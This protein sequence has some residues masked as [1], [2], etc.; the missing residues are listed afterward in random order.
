MLHLVLPIDEDVA[1]AG[2]VE[3]LPPQLDE[4][5]AVPGVTTVDVDVE[6]PL[7][8]GDGAGDDHTVAHRH[9]RRRGVDADRPQRRAEVAERWRSARR[10]EEQMHG[11]GRRP[12]D[13]EGAERLRRCPR[14]PST[15]ADTHSRPIS[16]RAQV[17][18]GTDEVRA[19]HRD[20]GGGGGQHQRREGVGAIGRA[21][22][23][24]HAR[25]GVVDQPSDQRH[26][27]DREGQ[28]GGPVTEQ[29]PPAADE[30][31]EAQGQHADLRDVV[32]DVPHEV[33]RVGQ[34]CHQ[35]D[36]RASEA[37]GPSATAAALTNRTTSETPSRTPS[38]GRRNRCGRSGTA[39]ALTVTRPG[40]RAD[41]LRRD[42]GRP[43]DP[44][45]TP[46]TSTPVCS[47]TSGVMVRTYPAP[48][49]V[50][51]IA[52]VSRPGRTS[53]G[54]V[55]RQEISQMGVRTLSAG[56]GGDHQQLR[57]GEFERH[58]EA[59]A[60]G[61]RQL[62]R[63]ALG[64]DGQ[65]GGLEAAGDGGEQGGPFGTHRQT[66]GHVLDERTGHDGAV[67]ASHRGAHVEVAVGRVRT[68]RG[69]RS[70]RKPV[71]R[72]YLSWRRLYPDRWLPIT[73]PAAE[74][75]RH[76]SVVRRWCAWDDRAN[77]SS[78]ENGPAS[79]SSTRPRA[80]A[81][82]S[83]PASSPPATWAG[84]GRCRARST[85]R[86]LDQLAQRGYLR[87]VGEEPGIAGGNRTILAATRTGRAQLRRWL[88]TPVDHLRDL[89][90]ELLLKLIIADICDIDVT[91]MLGRQHQHI[92]RA[93]RR[94][95]G[96]PDEQP[97]DVV[98]LWRSESSK[99]ALRFLERLPGTDED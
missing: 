7:V 29:S 75:S 1:A 6:Q 17:R 21:E 12:A 3:R 88:A 32:G 84:C 10:T 41:D 23:V 42:R 91:S 30:C 55:A 98:A 56:L 62:I 18:S 85:Y 53:C 97:G 57:P 48:P 24:D 90:S 74:G 40:P 81:S 51:G 86:S 4:E 39:K 61:E 82:P 52:T 27:P 93:D 2:S 44:T 49:Q 64:D 89:R 26:A 9:A 19:G 87:A 70:R 77:S 37:P 66:E 68:I 13:G 95:H 58:L 46:P 35:V 94:H 31:G 60:T 63:G 76:A 50:A 96:P 45:P 43:A 16:H 8:G 33:E 5:A 15:M 59:G 47:G 38:V 22:A 28:T 71:R 69:Q 79:A 36:E 14:T 54:A 67:G 80:T 72:R 34:R 99:A 20:G 92:A 78:S 73:A 11:G 25:R 65:R 83:P